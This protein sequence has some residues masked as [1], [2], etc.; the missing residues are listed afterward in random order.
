MA[1]DPFSPPARRRRDMLR[2]TAIA[3]LAL[4]GATN[5]QAAQTSGDPLDVDLS[6][7]PPGSGLKLVWHGQP[8]FVRHLTPAEIAAARSVAQADLRDPQTLEERT[9][10]GHRDWL[11]MI[12]ICPHLGCTP[13]GIAPGDPHGSFGGFVCP[14]HGSQFDAAG[15]VRAGPAPNNLEVPAYRFVGDHII[16]LD[17]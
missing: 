11:V 13:L 12:G 9:Q 1:G 14:C 4:G 15:R 17:T 7:I 16:R 10:P 6:K 3:G 5:A 2:L 8:L